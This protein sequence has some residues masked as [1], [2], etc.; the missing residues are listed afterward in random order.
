VLVA[1]TPGEQH[2]VGTQMVADFLEAGGWDVRHLGPS[3][4]AESLAELAHAQGVVAVAL[5]TA[6]TSSLG[7]VR[8]TCALLRELPSRP[9]IVVGGQAYRGRSELA[10][11]V[12][13]DAC[14]SSPPELLDHLRRH[15]RGPA[16]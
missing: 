1:C 2:A 16:R 15:A 14:L 8:R 7:E 12:G 10:E 13:A 9:H 5:S 4:P 3:T 11:S 6:L